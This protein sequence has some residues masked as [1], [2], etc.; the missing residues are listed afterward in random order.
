MRFPCYILLSILKARN[1]EVAVRFPSSS[2]TRKGELIDEKDSH[3]PE[4]LQYERHCAE[5]HEQAQRSTGECKNMI[6]GKSHV[7]TFQ[8]LKITWEGGLYEY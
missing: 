1:G 5:G 8:R 3:Q 7:V 6:I 4:V 2:T